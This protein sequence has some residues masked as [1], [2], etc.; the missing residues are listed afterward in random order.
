[1][2]D[3]DATDIIRGRSPSQTA[4]S[5]SDLN[6][7]ALCDYVVNVADGCSHGC[8]FCYVPSMPQIW[9]DPGDKFAEAGIEDPS[10]EWGDYALY[11][12]DVVA[13]TATG[14]EHIDDGGSDR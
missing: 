8:K 13:N 2:S 3:A 5:E 12:E 9:G 1:M 4:L 14:S 7:K 6:E 10:D 11:R